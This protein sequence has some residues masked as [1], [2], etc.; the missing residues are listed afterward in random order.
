MTPTK[1][2][3]FL[4]EFKTSKNKIYFF[5]ENK[6]IFIATFAIIGV[7]LG[8]IGY[9]IS[10]ESTGLEVLNNTIGLFVLQ[11]ADDDSMILDFAKFFALLTIFFSVSIY[12]LSKYLNELTVKNIQKNPYSL[13]IGLGVQNSYLLDS[14][15]DN[16]KKFLVIET[17]LNNQNIQNYK[18]KNI[19]VIVADAKNILPTI[20]TNKMEFCIISTGNDRQNIAIALLLDKIVKIGD[21]K[22]Y[23]H[24]ENRTLNILFKQNVISLKN[25]IDIITYSIYEN[26]VKSLFLK[27]TVLGLQTDIAK[28]N[29]E[30]STILIGS[31]ALAE[32][33]VYQLSMLSI[34]P[35]ENRFTLHLIAPNAKS[36]FGKIKKL[37]TN[38]EKIPHLNIKC[39]EISYDDIDFYKHKV[40]NSRN[41]TNIIIATNDEE[42]NLEI[43]INLQ[44]TTYLQK[45]VK[46]KLKSKVFVALYH[47]LGLDRVIHNTKGA[48]TNFYTF[49]NMADASSYEVLV[50]ENLDTIAKLVNNDYTKNSNAK[51][52]LINKEWIDLT[53]HKKGSNKAQAMH[54]DTKISTLSLKKQKSNKPIKILIEENKKIIEKFIPKEQRDTTF[55]EKFDTILSK[56]AN[57]E[58]NRWNAFHYLNGW[59]YS[60][61]RD[62]TIKKHPCLLPF[63]EFTTKEQKDTYKYDVSAVLNIPIYLAYAGYELVDLCIKE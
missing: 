20:D 18:S 50:D 31:S 14:I 26:M 62:D 7:I 39:I 8:F 49:A 61:R 44:D 22:I 5:I 24:I 1:L 34:L 53:I 6:H 23:V 51:K 57:S 37:F 16:N 55:P 15:K 17:N 28:S 54:I 13:L 32:E 4:T 36:F 12:F 48:Y 21:K 33:L 9:C 63:S 2:T 52:S 30:Y 3:T 35:N 38:I 25:R 42:K 27:H 41:L 11:W 46:G 45:S 60:I 29:I 56:L 47:N 19:G 58:H 43:A 10:D 40:Y 59:E